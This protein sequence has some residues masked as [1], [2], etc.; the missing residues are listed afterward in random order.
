MSV[1]MERVP[2][3]HIFVHALIFR[4]YLLLVLAITFITLI[5]FAV[6]VFPFGLFLLICQWLLGK[7]YSFLIPPILDSTLC[8]SLETML[9]ANR[10]FHSFT[11]DDTISIASDWEEIYLG[12]EKGGSTRIHS[13]IARSKLAEL[14]NL[15]WLHGV[16]GTATLSFV[17]SGVIDK[18]AN[19]FN[20]YAFDLPGFGRSTADSRLK[21]ASGNCAK[22]QYVYFLP[23]NGT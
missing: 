18:L 23:I 12:S 19:G 9:I 3:F 14:P 4:T 6:A 13:V 2:K 15:V 20:I 5:I 1:R 8:E 7:H 17:L 22:H 11:R 10:S 16:G 21:F